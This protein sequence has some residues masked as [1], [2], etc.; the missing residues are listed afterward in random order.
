MPP[1]SY[2]AH[3]EQDYL[4]EVALAGNISLLLLQPEAIIVSIAIHSDGDILVQETEL[5]HKNYSSWQ[6]R[7]LSQCMSDHMYLYGY[8]AME[9]PII[10]AA[11]MFLIKAG[12]QVVNKLFTF[13]RHGHQLALRPE[14]TVSATYHYM[15]EY[16]RRQ[17]IARWQFNGF[18]F[19][20]DPNIP[21]GNHQHFSIGAELIGMKDI[22]GD[23]E[24]IGMA[25][26]GLSQAGIHD[27]RLI[28]GH[29]GLIRQL[30]ARFHLDASTEHFL[31]G[32]LSSLKSPDLGKTFVM[33]QMDKLL[34]G[35]LGRQTLDNISTLDEANTR[36]VLDKMFDTRYQNTGTMG[37]RTQQDITRRLLHKRRRFVAR[38]DIVSAIELLDRLTKINLHPTEAFKEIY[39]VISPEDSQTHYLL[40]I[41]IQIT[42]LLEFYGISKEQILIQPDLARSWDYYSG[43]V[44][45]LRARDGGHLGGGGRYDGLTRLIGGHQDAPAVGFAY[46][47]DEIIS[48]LPDT[49]EAKPLSVTMWLNTDGTSRLPEHAGLKPYAKN[50]LQ[51][52]CCR[53]DWNRRLMIV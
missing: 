33:E 7:K 43:I 35:D 14:F 21:N 41:W 32:Y 22:V 12:D 29:T 6:I 11:D 47:A 39:N 48:M 40:S 36:D 19:E 28:L 31:L 37:G 30:L 44:F 27:W 18:V 34:F 4:P 3:I 1:A 49:S 26:N 8:D 10:E 46:Y 15:S 24:V 2:L 53:G 13:E 20:D 51:Y 17:S 25:A 50:P 45:E 52:R 38:D 42:N 9:L 16:A 5:Q 23:A